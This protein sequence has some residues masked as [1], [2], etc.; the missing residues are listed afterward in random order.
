MDF[1]F[2]ILFIESHDL[3]TCHCYSVLPLDVLFFQALSTW[4]ACDK[5]DI[6]IIQL[7]LARTNSVQMLLQ[8]KLVKA[9]IQPPLSLLLLHLQLS[10]LLRSS[11][12]VIEYQSNHAAEEDMGTAL[13]VDTVFQTRTP[14]YFEHNTDIDFETFQLVPKSRSQGNKEKIVGHC[15]HRNNSMDKFCLVNIQQTHIL[16]EGMSIGSWVDGYKVMKKHDKQE[17]L[18]SQMHL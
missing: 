17:G 3:K 1:F 16:K 8:K 13:G 11:Q 15:K 18:Q 10:F 14:G 7:K 9:P 2:L 12:E 5:E 6:N 4:L